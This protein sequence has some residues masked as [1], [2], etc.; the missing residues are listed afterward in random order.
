MLLNITKP[1]ITKTI[2]ITFAKTERLIVIKV[3]NIYC[4]FIYF[5]FALSLTLVIPS[6]IFLSPGF[7]P[8]TISTFPLFIIPVYTSVSAT[9]LSSMS[10]LTSVLFPC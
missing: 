2:D 5:I 10:L 8:A 3:N 9:V 4:L 6:L 7:K 1:N